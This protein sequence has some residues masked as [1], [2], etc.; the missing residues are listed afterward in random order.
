MLYSG[1]NILPRSVFWSADFNGRSDN[2]DVIP[3]K[4]SMKF[5]LSHLFIVI[6]LITVAL[7]WWINLRHFN[8]INKELQNQQLR[9]AAALRIHNP[10]DAMYIPHDEEFK[11][12]DILVRNG[13]S[14]S[15][16]RE[17]YMALQIL[18]VHES[19]AEIEDKKLADSF[20][21]FAMAVNRWKTADEVTAVVTRQRLLTDNY[22]SLKEPSGQSFSEL[23]D[24][25]SATPN[26]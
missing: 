15:E 4:V 6:L 17:H 23:I 11:L 26:Q 9:D 3:L 2:L 7:S 20:I 8:K 13:L 25:L 5:T 19:Y 14:E 18:A 10:L 24:R 21:R 12:L 22:I 1:F 16:M